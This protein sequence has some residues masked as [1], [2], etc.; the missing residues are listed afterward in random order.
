MKQLML[1]LLLC[2][3]SYSAAVS[4]VTSQAPQYYYA[5]QYDDTSLTI[6][7]NL[8]PL[9]FS[10]GYGSSSLPSQK[11][12]CIYYPRNFKYPPK[13]KITSL[14]LWIDIATTYDTNG[15]YEFYNVKWQMGTT[16]RDSFGYDSINKR[17]LLFDD[18]KELTTVL[19]ANPY[20]L[21][22]SSGLIRTSNNYKKWLKIPLQ[23]PFM[24]DPNK[25][26]V[27]Q[28]NNL[29]MHDTS[30]GYCNITTIGYQD[31]LS[32]NKYR[33]MG[34]PDSSGKYAYVSFSQPVI[35]ALSCIGFDLDT[36][37]VSG[38]EEVYPTQLTLYPNPAKTTIHFSIKGSYTI[39]TLQGAIEQQG[40]GDVANIEALPQGLY[41]VQLTTKN[42]ERLVG[43]FLKE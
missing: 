37:G 21:D 4:Q 13:G 19:Q 42:G 3:G 40:E 36:T 39:S 28:I 30:H 29:L 15:L 25:N 5:P 12:V 10:Q 20:I 6:V 32:P 33:T 35:S 11:W 43:R 26:L 23:V 16:T 7:S 8:S 18:E 38:V 14:Y 27:L 9:V 22:S 24:F 41:M 2:L 34:V 1:L 17:F 31:L